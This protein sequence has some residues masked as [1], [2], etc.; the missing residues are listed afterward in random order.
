MVSPFIK[1]VV[2]DAL[3]KS[4]HISTDIRTYPLNT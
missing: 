3:D 2:G 4:V 1:E